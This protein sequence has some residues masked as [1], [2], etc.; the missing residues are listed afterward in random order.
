MVESLNGGDDELESIPEEELLELEAIIAQG[1]T[2]EDLKVAREYT[3]QIRLGARLCKELLAVR[4]RNPVLYGLVSEITNLE[5][6]D[7]PANLVFGR[8][9]APSDWLLRT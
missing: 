9:L 4:K 3:E 5:I 1:D 6:T 8:L 7:D 2:P